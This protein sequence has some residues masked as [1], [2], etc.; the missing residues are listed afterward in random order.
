MTDSA[1]DVSRPGSSDLNIL[2][3]LELI[4]LEQPEQNEYTITTEAEAQEILTAMAASLHSMSQSMAAG[5]D[6]RVL[7]DYAATY[8]LSV[9]RQDS[10]ELL[11]SITF[12]PDQDDLVIWG[13]KL[14]VPAIV[15]M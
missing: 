9:I 12:D 14:T 11:R 10:L 4:S 1:T 15:L 7:L 8:R 5:P 6:K 2:E 3:R 13:L